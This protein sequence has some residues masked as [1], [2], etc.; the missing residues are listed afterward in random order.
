[1]QLNTN[2][3][4]F[5]HR[6]AKFATPRKVDCSERNNRNFELG[7]RSG[8]VGTR[9]VLQKSFGAQTTKLSVWQNDDLTVQKW[10]NSEE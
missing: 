8:R 5:M 4:V 9:P 3:Y 7:L 10:D 2:E 1:M 6:D